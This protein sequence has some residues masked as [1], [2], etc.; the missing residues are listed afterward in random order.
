M[1]LGIFAKTFVRPTLEQNLD[2]IVAH[3][4]HAT[5]FNLACAGLPSMPDE[6]PQAAVERIRQ[7]CAARGLTLAAVSGTYNMIHPDPVERQAGLRRLGVLMAACARLGA[8][9]ITLCTGTRDPENMWRRH[10]D[11]DMPEAW[12]DLLTSLEQALAPAETYGV[13]LAF[14]PEPGNVIHGAARGRRLLDELQSPRLKVIV[15]GAN[16]LHP[17]DLGRQTQIFDEAFDL[18][19][20]DMVLAHAKDLDAQGQPGQTG[21][22]SGCLDFDH[23]LA[24]LQRS[25]YNGPLIVHGLPES[26]VASSLAYLRAKL[27]RPGTLSEG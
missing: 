9:V 16:L 15:D 20:Q 23:Y 12:R 4:L 24:L 26:A 1:Q 13:T 8:P 7:G 14:E 21:P 22:G 19:G 2:A 25:G 10:P 11:N 3:G 18:L 6:I 17:G 5:Q 27:A